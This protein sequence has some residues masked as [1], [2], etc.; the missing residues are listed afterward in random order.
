MKIRAWVLDD[1][2]GVRSLVSAI[3]DM[4]GYD[5]K[6]YADPKSCLRRLRKKVGQGQRLLKCG[7]VII[8]DVHM[9]GMTGFEFLEQ[10][11]VQRCDKHNIAL[12]SA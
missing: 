10:N 2:E 7:D 3:L 9:P 5:T 1:D 8:S 4:R 12:M 11:K 6:V